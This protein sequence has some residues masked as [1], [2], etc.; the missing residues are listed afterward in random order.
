MKGA[1]CSREEEKF[2]I[3]PH[4]SAA[5]LR[6]GTL[7]SPHVSQAKRAY[8]QLHCPALLSLAIMSLARIAALVAV[9]VVCLLSTATAFVSGGGA[10]LRTSI[11]CLDR[12]HVSSP[13]RQQQQQRQLQHATHVPRRRLGVQSLRAASDQ[14]EEQGGFVNPYTAF[15]KWQLDLVRRSVHLGGGRHGGVFCASMLPD[16][17]WL[18]AWLLPL[19]FCCC[20]EF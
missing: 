11:L 17:G 20:S 19:A 16:A 7:F 3:S 18:L 8:F 12:T 2:K 5:L 1:G 4:F 14:E 15:R 10:A 6:K 9:L 13:L